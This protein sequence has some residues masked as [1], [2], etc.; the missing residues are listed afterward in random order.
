MDCITH[1]GG[2][3][4]GEDRIT[5]SAC[6]SFMWKYLSVYHVLVIYKCLR[7]QTLP[8]RSHFGSPFQNFGQDLSPPNSLLFLSQA[9]AVIDQTNIAVSLDFPNSL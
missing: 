6:S 9:D 1:V 5:A 4:G 7:D 3:K 2:V 8:N